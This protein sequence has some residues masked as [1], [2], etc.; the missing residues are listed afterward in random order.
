MTEQVAWCVTLSKVIVAIILP[1]MIFRFP[2]KWVFAH[3][4]EPEHLD[5]AAERLD[6]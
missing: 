5:F 1:L 3:T 2:P 6:I 4:E